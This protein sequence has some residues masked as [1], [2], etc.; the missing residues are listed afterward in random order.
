[1][2]FPENIEQKLGFDKIRFLISEQCLSQ[3]GQHWVEQ[4]KWS[5]HMSK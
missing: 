4:M 5:T 3:E 2:I 1:M